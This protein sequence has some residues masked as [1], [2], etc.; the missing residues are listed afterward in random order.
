MMMIALSKSRPKIL[1][2][3]LFILLIAV[4]LGS[5]M[6]VIEGQKN[7]FESIADSIYWS[8]VTLTTVGYGDVVPVTALGK[9]IS[10]LIMLLGDAIIA[11]P[12]GIVS[13]E[14]AKND[15]EQLRNQDEIMEK[16]NQYYN[17][18]TESCNIFIFK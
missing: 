18:N 17:Q 13:A 10:V 9:T 3:V 11:V 15:L 1:A 4:V 7:G 8:V 6:Y 5:L 16:E 14:F 12:T 2:F